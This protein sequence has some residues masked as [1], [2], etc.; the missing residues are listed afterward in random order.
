MWAARTTQ[1]KVSGL[2][3]FSDLDG[4]VEEK[5]TWAIP[6][7][8]I[9]LTPLGSWNPYGLSMAS[10]NDYADA[11][12]RD[13]GFTAATAFNGSNSRVFYRTPEEFFGN[14]SNGDSADTTQNVVGVLDPQGNVRR[15]RASGIWVFFPPIPGVGDQVRQ[16]FPIAPVHHKKNPGIQQLFALKHAILNVPNVLNGS[17]VNLATS[18]A[19]LI[20]SA[21]TD[22]SRHIHD[23]LI[24]GA[25]VD[26]LANAQSVTVDT[27]LANGHT[28]TIKLTAVKVGDTLVFTMIDCDDN[29]PTCPDGHTKVCR[30]GSSCV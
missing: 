8:L 27:D 7:E 6:I 12:G 16:R 15:C 10:G 28:H 17:F 5:W 25:L 1:S 20:T 21:G 2:K 11:N 22:V 3:I 18:P 9:Y 23:L 26:A 24:P 19:S 30:S 14:A 4:Y 13:G 29:G